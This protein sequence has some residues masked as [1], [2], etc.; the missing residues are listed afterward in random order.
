[1]AL[2]VQFHFH[3]SAHVHSGIVCS[4]LSVV[5]EIAGQH[6][7]RAGA[8]PEK[9]RCGL[10]RAHMTERTAG[11]SSLLALLLKVPQIVSGV[12]YSMGAIKRLFRISKG[13]CEIARLLS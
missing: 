5:S 13:S 3:H 1:M 12:V 6:V 7:A 2:W 10:S 9:N 8:I 11:L 4:H